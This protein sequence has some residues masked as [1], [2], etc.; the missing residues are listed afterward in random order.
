MFFLFELLKLRKNPQ[1]I[2]GVDFFPKDAAKY[3]KEIKAEKE[4][5]ENSKKKKI[6]KREVITEDEGDEENG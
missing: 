6:L 2:E 1:P 5:K 4:E 3:I